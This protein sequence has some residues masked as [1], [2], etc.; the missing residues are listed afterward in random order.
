MDD[1]NLLADSLLG[2]MVGRVVSLVL[3]VRVSAAE[4]LARGGLGAT[5]SL[6][7]LYI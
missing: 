4:V 7:L 2:L 3:V 5:F 1:G 6:L